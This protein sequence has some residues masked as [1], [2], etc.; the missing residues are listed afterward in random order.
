MVQVGGFVS[1]EKTVLASP[2]VTDVVHVKGLS[3]FPSGET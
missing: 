3:S 2:L 1:L